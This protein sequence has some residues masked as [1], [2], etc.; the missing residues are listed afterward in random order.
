MLLIELDEHLKKYPQ[1]YSTNFRFSSITGLVEEEIILEVH[2]TPYN[3]VKWISSMISH[4]YGMI[5]TNMDDGIPFEV[6]PYTSVWVHFPNQHAISLSVPL[7]DS[8]L[9]QKLS[10]YYT[11]KGIQPNPTESEDLL[12][13]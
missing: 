3:Q 11:P 2:H 8:L 1:D 5:T 6:N 10:L 7:L 13:F 4:W 9:K 12:G